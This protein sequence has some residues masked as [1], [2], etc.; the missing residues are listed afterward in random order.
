MRARFVT[1]VIM[2]PRAAGFLGGACLAAIT[3]SVSLQ[4]DILKKKDLTA[5]HV[6]SIAQEASTIENR[7]R[8]VRRGFVLL[9]QE[10]RMRRPLTEEVL[11][12]GA[13]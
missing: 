5:A 3:A 8:V 7:L 13:T 9:Q 10:E 2:G 4:Y 11:T 1:P 6:V 12:P